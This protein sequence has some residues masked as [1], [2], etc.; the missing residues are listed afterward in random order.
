MLAALLLLTL[1]HDAVARGGLERLERFADR[2]ELTVDPGATNLLS[3]SALAALRRWPGL[4]TLELRLPIAAA[5]ATQLR[6]L[7]RFAARLRERK[8]P[9]T[10]RPPP[11]TDDPAN[12]PPPA[13]ELKLL[14]PALVRVEPAQPVPA[15]AGPC[16]GTLRSPGPPEALRV[17]G[18]LDECVLGWIADRLELRPEGTTRPLPID[19]ARPP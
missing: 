13:A 12:R 19:P 2:L 4:V 15:L 16:P 9:L 6:R 1:G 18:A 7:G 3:D 10:V 14:A 8:S 5:E 11:A 17:E